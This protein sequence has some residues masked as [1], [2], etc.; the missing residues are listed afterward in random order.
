MAALFISDLHLCATR[1]DI[2]HS[3]LD[4]LGGPAR[5]AEAL[6]VL[7]DLFEA[8]A[9]DD[10]ID[11]PFNRSIVDGLAALSSHGTNISVLHG[12]RDF[13]LAKDF[14]R[15]TGTSLLP[16]PAKIDLDGVAVLLLHGD[17]LCTADAD[18]LA[19]RAQV[20]APAWIDGFLAQPL[21]TRKV[22]IEALRRQSDAE[23][24]RK[25]LAAMDV[26]QPAV[27]TLVRSHGYPTLIHGHTH[28]P[29]RHVFDVDGHRCERWVL[30]D[31]CQTGGYLRYSTGT[32]EMVS[33][34]QQ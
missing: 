28:Q 29:A 15:L 2:A 10:D 33:V 25:P 8:W 9:G 30:S 24:S 4:F 21:A 27:E 20:R 19:F 16:E 3:F 1:P 18:Y 12:N 11:D 22:Q 7:G 5:E 34:P 17:T 32:W 13:L 23:K 14:A 26:D 6:Y 31:W